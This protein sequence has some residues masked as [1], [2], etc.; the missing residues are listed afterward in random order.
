MI[1]AR[2]ETAF[3]IADEV[4]VGVIAQRAVGVEEVLAGRGQVLQKVPRQRV[5]HRWRNHV[6]RELGK[7]AA[8]RRRVAQ[9]RP[10]GEQLPSARGT[11][12]QRLRGLGGSQVADDG[13]T[14][15]TYTKTK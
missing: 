14:Y 7:G 10:R 8:G 1:D 4:R 2:R 9:P 3:E 11:D 5:Q 6:V 13:K 15:K 12:R